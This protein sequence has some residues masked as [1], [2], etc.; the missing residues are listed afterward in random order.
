MPASLATEWAT[1]PLRPVIGRGDVHVWCAELDVSDADLVALDALLDPGERAR[2]AR[3]RFN[4]HRTRWVAAHGMLRSVLARYV[5]VPAGTLEFAAE[6]G[7]KPHLRGPRS[8]REVHFNLAHAEGIAL[9]AVS[10]LGEVG[11]DVER[12]QP[13]P[14]A[15]VIAETHFAEGE[16]EGLR[17]LQPARVDSGF[18]SCWTRK[19]A[20]VKAVGSGLAM[21]LEDFEVTLSPDDPPRFVH[22]GGDESAATEWSLHSLAPAPGYTG[23]VAIR[24]PEITLSCWRWP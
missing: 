3:F 24:A 2:A 15:E 12:V 16:R 20:Y 8:D 11:V 21:P 10:T 18:F 17:R 1:G 14:D 13:M 22:I 9:L 7:G 4:R 19:E 6:P 23:A 5:Q